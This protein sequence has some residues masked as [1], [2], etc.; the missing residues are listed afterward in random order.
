[1]Y[2][3]TLSGIIMGNVVI[4]WFVVMQVNNAGETGVTIDEERFK[5]FKDGAGFVSTNIYIL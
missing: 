3:D 2:D 4:V 1:M 5:T